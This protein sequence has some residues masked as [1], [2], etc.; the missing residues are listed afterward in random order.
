MSSF[1]NRLNGSR[2]LGITLATL[3]ATMIVGTASAA[4]AADAPSVKVSYSDL[5]LTSDAG[6]QVLYSRIVSAAR[7]VCFARDVDNRDL[8]AVIASRSCVNTAI[9]NAVST[10]HSE[11]L[12]ALSSARSARG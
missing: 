10:I 12:A 5:N 9:A 1:T 7:N 8:G 2:F 4:G 11:R 3:A 6:T